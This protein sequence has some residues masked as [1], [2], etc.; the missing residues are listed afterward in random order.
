MRSAPTIRSLTLSALAALFLSTSGAGAA[1]LFAEDFEG[2]SSG[3][4]VAG[5]NGW[6]GDNI[7]TNTSA[8]FGGST[9]LDGTDFSNTIDGFA[10]VERQFGS[11][12]GSGNV[13]EFSVDVFGQTSSLPSH[14]SAMGLGSSASSALARNGAHWT[15]LYDIGGVSGRTGFQFAAQGITGNGAAFE[16]FDGPFNQIETL[17]IVID[18]N[19]GE[20]WGV[21][22]FGAGELET[23]HFSVSTAQIAAID[24]VFGFTD[25]RAANPG[26]P[27]VSTPGGSQFAGAQWDNIVV[28][29]DTV[30]VP[31]PAAIAFLGL[32]LLGL[33]WS[34]RRRRSL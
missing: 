24:Q 23:S 12:N 32:G 8:N 1:V 25:F 27:F 31:E 26:G 17:K 4:V 14:N 3:G 13:Y 34:Q 21:Y 2:H 33:G 19:V 18:G 11:L 29:D 20:V 22:D 10:V 6:T 28:T 30:E 16:V 5:T 15:A 7:N 9:V